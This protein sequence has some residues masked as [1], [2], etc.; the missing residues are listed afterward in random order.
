MALAVPS[1]GEVLNP[2]CGEVGGSN[3]S[4][5][6]SSQG[7]L[8]LEPYRCGGSRR[9]GDC[10]RWVAPAVPLA[11]QVRLWMEHEV[12]HRA[13]SDQLGEVVTGINV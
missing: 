12:L 7:V 11:D 3:I 5:A 9:D 4:C 8:A 1:T 2:T 13:W 10:R 6:P